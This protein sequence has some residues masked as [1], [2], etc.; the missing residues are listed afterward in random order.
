MYFNYE[1]I[2]AKEDAMPYLINAGNQGGISAEVQL[3]IFNIL[4]A[5]MTG[6]TITLKATGLVGS[7]LAPTLQDHGELTIHVT[8]DNPKE[9][10]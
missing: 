9:T 4:K 10:K 8:Y 3:L 6:A 5:A 1:F 7:E 2:G